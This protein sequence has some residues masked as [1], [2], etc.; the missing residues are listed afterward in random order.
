MMKHGENMTRLQA[1]CVFC[2]S[3]FGTN[4]VYRQAATKFGKVLADNKI[5]LVYGGGGVGLMGATA[6]A[7]HDAGG[8]VTG[9]GPQALARIE[10]QYKGA[11]EKIVTENMH[12]RKRNMFDLADAFVVLPGGIGT[13]EETVE[14]LSWAY[15][16]FHHKPIVILNID[17]YWKPFLGLIDHVIEQGFAK[18]DILKSPSPNEVM[19]VTKQ[20]EDILPI[21][22]KALR[23]RAKNGE[24]IDSSV[25]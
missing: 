7:T 10:L 9:I 4:G 3:N 15:L 23:D 12:D 19:F 14:V 20:V 25:Y 1:V 5:R 6:E 18:P 2:G 21:I 13:L 24:M 17:N 16:G 11:D 8:H 22:T